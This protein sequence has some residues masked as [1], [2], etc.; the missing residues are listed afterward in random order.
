MPSRKVFSYTEAPVFHADVKKQIQPILTKFQL[1]WTVVD[2]LHRLSDLNSSNTTV[3][4]LQVPRH[5]NPSNT[6]VGGQL[7]VCI[8]DFGWRHLFDFIYRCEHPSIHFR[9]VVASWIRRCESLVLADSILEDPCYIQTL[10]DGRMDLQA[11]HMDAQRF[12]VDWHTRVFRAVRASFF[13]MVSSRVQKA[14]YDSAYPAL[15]SYLYVSSSSPEPVC[16]RMPLFHA[17]HYIPPCYVSVLCLSLHSNGFVISPRCVGG[18][19]CV[20]YFLWIIL[21]LVVPH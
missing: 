4:F 16:P 1:L 10:R 5:T 8:S 11:W 20:S 15:P 17:R 7:R 13:R 9:S 14:V 2:G 18:V 21:M 3:P 6:P 12:R 19:A